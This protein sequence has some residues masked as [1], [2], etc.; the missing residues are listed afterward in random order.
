MIGTPP[1]ISPRYSATNLAYL[2]N[3]TLKGSI[4]GLSIAWRRL[5]ADYVSLPN[6]LVEFTDYAYAFDLGVSLIPILL[7]RRRNVQQE[8]C[9]PAVCAVDSPL[10]KDMEW[11]DAFLEK[12]WN[13]IRH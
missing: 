9:P 7:A 4:F 8:D 5:G 2:V 11:V 10:E 3:A 1:S 12:K 13:R 6:W